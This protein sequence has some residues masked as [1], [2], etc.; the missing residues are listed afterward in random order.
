MTSKNARTAPVA[1]AARAATAPSAGDVPDARWWV[2]P[3]VATVLAPL[4]SLVTAVTTDLFTDAPPVFLVGCFV[5]PFVAI[6][7][8]WCR[9][10]TVRE[11]QAR[12]GLAVVGCFLAVGYTWLVESVLMTVFFVMLVTG[13]GHS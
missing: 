12:N 2:V 5:L 4:L 13:L 3:L 8:A 10:R 7:P 6:V 1:P 9:P 11:R